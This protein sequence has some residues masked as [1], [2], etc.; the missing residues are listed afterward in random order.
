MISPNRFC[1]MNESVC[2]FCS[3]GN[4]FFIQVERGQV[5]L[6]ILEIGLEHDHRKLSSEVSLPSIGVLH[7]DEIDFVENDD[8]FL[9][10]Q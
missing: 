7:R 5:G 1:C 3:F 8:D 6:L 2:H 10:R 9:V 4:R